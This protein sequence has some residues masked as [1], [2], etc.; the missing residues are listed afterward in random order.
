MLMLTWAGGSGAAAQGILDSPD[1]NVILT[2]GLGAG[3]TPAYP[4]SDDLVLRPSGTLRVDFFR[5]PN[6]F[7]YSSL[8][9]T[10]VRQGFGLYGSAR[11]IGG[12]DVSEYPDLTGL[13]D[14]PWTFEAGLGIGYEFPN[15]RVFGDVRYG[16]HGHE[17]FVGT[18][19]ADLIARPSEKLVVR[20]GPRAEFGSDSYASTY[21]G[22]TPSEA[23]AGSLSA[24]DAEGGLM[25]AGLELWAVYSFNERWGIEGR[26][27]WLRLLNAAADSPVTKVG[28]ADQ[29]RA[30]MILTRRVNLDF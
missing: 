20:F 16:F 18:L 14:V 24:F 5:L 17:S 22:V 27:G 21:F 25:G 8:G 11:Y 2:F 9:S 28:S 12:R 30:I 7:T 4:G 19:G 1:P 23:A 26:A 15:Y 3:F 13:D 6:G 10:A 29:F